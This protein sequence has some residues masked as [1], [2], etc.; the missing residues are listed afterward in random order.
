M[1]AASAL[2]MDERF[3]LL[4]QIVSGDP[5]LQARAW[6]ELMIDGHAG[7][8]IIDEACGSED[9]PL[10]MRLEQLVPHLKNLDSPAAIALRGWEHPE[11]DN[12]LHNEDNTYFGSAEDS[13]GFGPGMRS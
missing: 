11:A 10:V 9:R 4:A 8:T 13:G 6:H 2:S 12:R 3:E 1:P 7:A 5:Q